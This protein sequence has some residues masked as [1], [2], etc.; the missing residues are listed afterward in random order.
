MDSRLKAFPAAFLERLSQLVPQ[1]LLKSVADGFVLGRPHQFRLNALKGEPDQIIQ[2]LTRQKVPFAPIREI[3]GGFVFG[4]ISEKKIRSLA[5]YENGQIYLQNASSQLPPLIL[6]PQ[7]GDSILDL[8]ASPGSKTSQM[9]S[10]TNGVCE[11]LAIEPDNIRFA[12]LNHNLTHQGA[13]SCVKTVQGYGE[14]V[15][16]K[17][18]PERLFDRILVDAPCSGEGTFTLSHAA[19][20]RHWKLEFVFAA[21]KRQKKLLLAAYNKLKPGGHLVYS[22]CALS[23]E[24]NEGVLDALFK[25]FPDAILE[26]NRPRSLTQVLQPG[27]RHWKETTF[28]P[29]VISASRVFPSTVFEGFFIASLKKPSSCTAS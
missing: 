9:A 16:N 14:S 22:T 19:G 8:C 13:L 2:S 29:R 21:A 15:L 24:E 17:L 12:R 27:V 3:P 7:P 25:N 23:P 5:E 26:V 10:M 28:D 20:F 1:G 6:N 4:K 18:A 11:I